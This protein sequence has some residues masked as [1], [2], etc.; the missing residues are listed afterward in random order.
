MQLYVKQSDANKPYL[1]KAST[2]NL[3][4]YTLKSALTADQVIKLINFPAQCYL[5]DN[6]AVI[7]P[8]QVPMSDQ[9]QSAQKLALQVNDLNSQIAQLQSQLTASQS[10]D[11]AKDNTIKALQSQVAQLML[12]SVKPVTNGGAKNE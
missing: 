1:E 10:D 6:G 12:A 8:N 7:V 9:E 11:Q 2:E 4:G 3:D 5:D